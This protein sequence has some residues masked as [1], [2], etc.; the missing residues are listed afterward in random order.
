MD[1][2]KGIMPANQILIK[3]R[4]LNDK[5]AD[6]K[7]LIDRA[8]NEMEHT[9]IVAEVIKVCDRVFVKD[10]DMNVI[11]RPQELKEGDVVYCHYLAIQNAL[12]RWRQKKL[13]YNPDGRVI[14]DGDDKYLIINYPNNVFMAIRDGFP[15]PVND[16]VLIEPTYNELKKI[17]VEAESSGI[18][19]PESM[20]EKWK[21]NTRYGTVRYVGQNLS[22][23]DTGYSD[24][25]LK[26]G[27]EV[28]IS[29]YADIPLEY[30]LHKTFE[31]DK[32][33]C[34]VLRKD[35]LM[36]F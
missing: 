8:F 10:E 32:K 15:I 7:L 18:A 29:K 1:F 3:P 22:Q 11:V 19:V 23:S 4:I 33:L 25:V 16:F 26:P 5:I 31:K 28:F 34:R 24:E 35:I 17:Q 27:A 20:I 30:D 2:K 13:V 12:K 21:E 6:G 36:I 14:M 9:D